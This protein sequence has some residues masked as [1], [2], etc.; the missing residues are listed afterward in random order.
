MIE[1]MYVCQ[2]CKGESASKSNRMKP[3]SC[4][5]CFAENPIIANTSV[6]CACHDVGH[7]KDKIP[8]IRPMSKSLESQMKSLVGD[9][10]NINK[11]RRDVAKI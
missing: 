5:D 1:M 11:D 2:A 3:S 7:D 4:S 9:E 10:E 8:R 6:S